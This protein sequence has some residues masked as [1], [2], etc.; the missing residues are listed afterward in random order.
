MFTVTL[1]VTA[2]TFLLTF[3]VDWSQ[4]HNSAIFQA[5]EVSFERFQLL[6]QSDK[7]SSVNVRIEH[8]ETAVQLIEHNPILGVGLG[9]FGIEGYGVDALMYPHNMFL[10][11]WVE[12]GFLS[13]VLL[14]LIITFVYL[15]LFVEDFNLGVMLIITYCLLNSMKSLSY[16]DN[17]VL[18]FWFAFG[19]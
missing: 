15:K 19:L 2:I 3:K 7:G 13:L 6:F 10:E 12:N 11:V 14:I 5:I 8:I 1:A 18:F 9:A 16:V 4:I 17:R